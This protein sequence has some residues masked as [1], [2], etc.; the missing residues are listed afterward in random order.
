MA[1]RRRNREGGDAGGV[2][3]M[4]GGHGIL[5]GASVLEMFS[6]MAEVVGRRVGQRLCM[7]AQESQ[8]G[9]LTVHQVGA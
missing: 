4:D 8:S 1:R 3:E 6:Q 2:Q 9:D 5:S 7:F